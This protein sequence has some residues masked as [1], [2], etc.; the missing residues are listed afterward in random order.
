M[1]WEKK[2]IFDKF[3]TIEKTW[4]N[5]SKNFFR[6]KI[7]IKK[8]LKKCGQNEKSRCLKKFLKTKNFVLKNTKNDLVKRKINIFSKFLQ[9]MKAGIML[10]PPM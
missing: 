10:N 1:G 8:N 6:K 7:K 9:K 2:A 4:K 3:Y 5:I